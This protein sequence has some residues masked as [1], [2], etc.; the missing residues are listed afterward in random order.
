MRQP[1][2]IT[3][4]DKKNNSFII[5]DEKE[6]NLIIDVN[7]ENWYEQNH[8]SYTVT[9]KA[10]KRGQSERWHSNLFTSAN[11]H[12]EI[13][14]NPYSIWDTQS[15]HDRTLSQDSSMTKSSMQTRKPPTVPKPF[16][17]S[18]SNRNIIKRDKTPEVTK[19]RVP[20]IFK[21]KAK[22]VPG[23]H[24]VPFMV[25]HSTK[26]LTNPEIFSL[27]TDERSQSRHRSNSNKQDKS[28]E[29]QKYSNIMGMISN[30]KTVPTNVK[31]KDSKETKENN[32]FDIDI[33]LLTNLI[34][35]EEFK[36]L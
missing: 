1:T 13:S 7:Q 9:H 14:E 33:D 35:A 28:S 31:S 11:K 25:L 5:K 3:K 18:S 27:K 20:K 10:E 12:D 34:K 15:K 24:R 30:W 16:R 6:S 2:E 17:L 21:F 29:G 26:N 23:S 19:E 22:K 36:D 32:M 8:A 4:T